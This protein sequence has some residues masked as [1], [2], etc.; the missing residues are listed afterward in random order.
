L[1]TLKY[2]IHKKKD[3]EVKI[4]TTSRGKWISADDIDAYNKQYG[5]LFLFINESFHDRYLI[6]DNKTM[7]E[8]GASIKDIGNK[9]SNI[10]KCEDKT[11][12][13]EIVSLLKNSD[14][15]NS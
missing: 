7:F 10:V 2:F 1:V 15:S 11:K 14:S 8:L 5:R 9:V 13:N 3:V 6:I 4:Y 12:I